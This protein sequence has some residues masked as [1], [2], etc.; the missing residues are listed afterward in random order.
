MKQIQSIAGGFLVIVSLGGGA[1]SLD[2]R[3]NKNS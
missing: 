1:F 2:S 3:F